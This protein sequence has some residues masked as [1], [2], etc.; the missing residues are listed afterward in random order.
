MDRQAGVPPISYTNYNRMSHI[1]KP[2]SHVVYF[3]DKITCV[4]LYLN[5]RKTTFTDWRTR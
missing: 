5:T 3:F 4:V 1:D 2:G